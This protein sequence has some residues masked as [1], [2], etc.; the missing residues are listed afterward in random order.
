MSIL[1]MSGWSDFFS[2]S[3]LPF[4]GCA[5]AA[6]FSLAGL[7]ACGT[8]RA[9]GG[10]WSGGGS[11]GDGSGKCVVVADPGVLGVADGNDGTPGDVS[12]VRG[13]VGGG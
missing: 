1:L 5:A 4:D 2:S 3:F 13:E 10:Y 7:A 9:G 8:G 12:G 6:F 11:S